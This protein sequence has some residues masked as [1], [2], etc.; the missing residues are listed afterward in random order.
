MSPQDVAET[1]D[2]SEVAHVKLCVLLH[3]G[4]PGEAVRQMEEHTRVGRRQRPRC[5][6]R[7]AMS[8]FHE[9]RARQ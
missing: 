1:L 6:G 5:A 3:S 9:W 7:D 8:A 2:V 4:S